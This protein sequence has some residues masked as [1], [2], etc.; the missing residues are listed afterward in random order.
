MT[1]LRK[2]SF[3]LLVAAALFGLMAAPVHAQVA[4]NCSGFP[5]TLTLGTHYT[6]SCFASGGVAP[7]GGAAAYNWTI[8]NGYPPGMSYGSFSNG[9]EFQVTG[10]P[11]VANTYTFTVTATDP[12]NN[13]GSASITAIVAASGGGTP[14]GTITLSYVSQTTIPA[15]QATTLTLVGTNFTASTVVYFNANILYPF[16]ISSSQMS[17][18]IPLGLAVAG[19]YSIYVHDPTTGTSTSQTITV[20]GSGGSGTLQITSL[21]P[22]SINVGYSQ[23]LPVYIYGSGFSSGQVVQF[24]TCEN[25]SPQYF[26]STELEINVPPSCFT[27][28]VTYNV[29]VGSS[30]AYQFVVGG[31]STGSG[32]ISLTSFAP[33]SLTAGLTQTLTLYGANFTPNTQVYFAGNYVSSTENSSGM[34]TATIPGALIT[35]GSLPVYVQ[36]VSTGQSAP[37][38]VPVTGSST[39]SGVTLSYISPNSIPAGSGSFTLSLFGS[40]FSNGN[41]VSFGSYNLSAVLVASGELQVAIPATYIATPGTLNV[42]VAGSNAQ[43]FTIT[44]SSTGSLTVTCS[45]ASGPATVN[46]AYSQTCSVSGGTSPYTWTVAGLPN[47]LSQSAYTGGSTVTISGTPTTQQ[48]YSYVV[49]V[50]DSSATRLIGSTTISGSVTSSTTSGYSITSLSPTSIPVGSGAT[51]LTVYGNGFTT[52]SQVYFNGTA[53]GTTYVSSTQL[54][55]S[56]A[57]SFL[58]TA[59]SDSVTVYT[60]GLYTNTLYL[61]VGSGSTS[62]GGLTVV[63]GPGVGPQTQYVLYSTICTASGGIQPYNWTTISLPSYLSLTSTT[64]SSVTLTGTPT[65]TGSYNFTVKV[66]DSSSPALSGSLQLAG[67]ILATSTTGGITLSSIS[68]TSTPVNS[69]T[70][71]LTLIG[72]GFTTSSQVTFSSIPITTTYVSGSELLATIPST[73]LTYSFAALI[74]VS[75]PGIGT[76]N[77]LSFIIGANVSNPVSITC[78]PGVGPTAPNIYYTQT[79]NANGGT[80]PFNWSIVSGALPAGLGL[81]S[82]T[83]VQTSITGYSTLNGPY[84]YTIQVVDSASPPNVGTAVFAG[85]TGTGTSTTNGLSLTSIAPGSIAPGAGN[86]TLTINGAGF[87]TSSVAYFNTTALA[88]TFVNS[89]QLTALIPSSLL[90]STTTA[91]ITVQSAGFTSNALSLS[92]GTGSSTAITISCS[93]T[94]GPPGSGA[95]YSTTCTATGGKAPYT[96]TIVN[97][98]L[99]TGIVL[100]NSNSA[101]ITISGVHISTA[102]SSEP[103][104]YTLQVTD[105]STPMQTADYPFAG[106]LPLGQGGVFAGTVTSMSPIS[107]PVNG[108]QFTLT[109][110]G[111]SFINGQSFILF[112]NTPL[113]T[114]Y[115]SSNELTGIVPASLL[116]TPGTVYVSVETSGIG[117]TNQVGFFVNGASGVAVAP[118]SLTFNYALG[119]VTPAAQTLSISSSTSVIVYSLSV[120][121]TANGI[122]WLSASPASG[123]IPGTVTVIAAPT[124]LAIGSYSGSITITGSGAGTGTTIPV[125]L[126]VLGTPGLK[127]SP[128]TMT[129]TAPAGTTSPTQTLQITSSDGQTPIPFTVTGVANNGGTW[130]SVTP[131]SGTTP[132]PVTVTTNAGS[133]PANT[134]YGQIN[135]TPTAG[136]GAALAI[137]VTFTVT[138][139]VTLTANPASLTFNGVTGQSNPAA[140]TVNLTASGSTAA[141][142][143]VAATTTSGGNWLTATASTGATPGT[144]SVTTNISG[145]AVGAYK[146]TVTVTSTGATNSPLAIPVTLNVANPSPLTTSPSSLTF[147]YQIGGST[148][149]AQTLNISAPSGSTGAF[150]YSIAAATNSGGNW[151]SVSSTSGTTPGSVSVSINTANLAVGSYSG[152]LTITASGAATTT[153]NV[154]LT[155]TPPPATLSVS[156]ATLTFNATAG[157]TSPS[158]QTVSV[159]TTNNVAA[160]Y[161]VTTSSAGNWLTATASGTTP[162]TISVSV[163]PASL[164]IGQYSGSLTIAS[165]GATNTPQTVNVTLNVAAPPAISVAPQSLS[166][167]VPGD[168]STPAPKTITVV[169]TGGNTNFT[170]SA[171]SQGGNWLSVTGG[172]TTPG[173]VVVSVNPAGLTPGQSYNGSVTINAPA[174][175]P[176]SLQVA[177]TL[178]LALQGAVPLQATPSALYLYYDQG[179]GSDLQHVLM[180]N[181]GGG[182]VLY[183]VVG[184]TQTCGNWLNVV[185]PLG[186]ATPST[187]GVV[188]ININPSGLNAQTCRGSI[189]IT[190]SNSNTATVPVYMAISSAAESI[191]LSQTA[192]N[193]VAGANGSA[194]AGQTFTILNPGDVSMPWNITTSTLSGGG[195]LSASP[196]AGNAPSLGQ[197]GTPI[198][199]TV[200]PQG[201]AAGV[202]YGTVQVAASGASNGPQSITVSLTVLGGNPPAQVTPDGVIL[203]GIN[204]N[205]NSQ[206]VNVTNSGSSAL[207]YSAIVTTDDGQNW[208]TV[209]PASGSISPGGTNAVNVSASLTG[210]G[211][212]LRHGTL[213]LAFSDG[214]VQTVDVQLALSGAASGSGVSA[215]GAANLAMEFLSPQQNFQAAAHVAIPI[216]V[217]VQDCLGNQLS[218]S[219]TGVD[220]LAGANN[221]DIRLNY[222]GNGIWA[223]TWT[224]ASASSA[225]SLTALAVEIVGGAEAAG[226]ITAN[227]TVTAAASNAPPLVSAVVNAGSFVLPGLVAPGTMVSIFG[228][229]LADGQ[230]QV[231]STPFPNSL[232][233]AQFSVKGVAMPLF[234]ASSGQVNAILPIGLTADER[235]QL[236]VVRDTTQSAPVDLLVADSDPGIFAVNSQGTGQGA[237]LVGGTSQ[238]A[239]P[240]GSIPGA[241]AAPASA[242]QTISMFVSGLGTVSNPPADGSPS[243]GNSLTTATPTVTIGGVPAQVTYSGLAPGEVGLYQV[244]AVV[245]AGVPTGSAVPVVITLGNGVSNT[246]TMAIQ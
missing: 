210:L 11:S 207:S 155:V 202:Y 168:G 234:Y 83:G 147:S 139:P 165:P 67:Q 183:Q 90:I 49:Q 143:T 95:N 26:G 110:L 195:W 19:S 153:V 101:T 24:G 114:T 119:G 138:A 245:P 127:A 55:A 78:S 84:S 154:A 150:N 221:A 36:D 22:S 151:L 40:N 194:P 105:S 178:T 170:A 209:S 223:G 92:I 189:S 5:S 230:V 62:S 97:G 142:Y 219:N 162:G 140:Q 128:L 156:P 123:T 60:S 7:T 197:P 117:N 112:G 107:A 59:G 152:T 188:G 68:P 28:A 236:I 38:Y 82:T 177:V 214:T 14:S 169:S 122:T 69:G 126:N 116:V 115:I 72:S 64:G 173:S 2:V 125:T 205:A 226:S 20:T 29:T 56:I 98:F 157:G 186:I 61:T 238:I 199:V 161:T 66:T 200:N 222:T 104:N 47:G 241:N 86:T 33:P 164:S 46:V 166:F 206:A 121:A 91:S 239:A 45:P 58:A 41:I 191:L 179:A 184:Q 111:N 240:S 201:L 93:P 87:G 225:S 233:G 52:S 103:Y 9:E 32:S 174:S 8:T 217:L 171:F 196:N 136:Y 133:L 65:S 212:G 71:T 96:W 134:Y 3:V 224:P 54:T 42:S 23:T 181:S 34:I 113:A 80:G 109:V 63:C 30:N 130:L 237:I 102:T 100:G 21:V 159:S 76:S 135:V 204:G 27:T 16:N 227:G 198:T 193:F 131:S 79:C 12:A 228:S 220:V 51:A 160:N 108:S 88:T 50:T 35:S 18:T 146:G 43:T 48:S 13:S 213:R 17:V 25:I 129:F 215:C 99:P 243:S 232:E 158:P 216:K 70:V 190:D 31:T 57:A 1:S 118:S 192:M 10:T 218:S 144:I 74:T 75:T 167:F 211:T 242:G 137:P 149:S 77:S 53:V 106:T 4:V 229:S 124:G 235:D 208:L 231:F 37:L 163:N 39:G 187:P 176:S 182:S 85:T 44:G 132:A 246:V 185:T 6:L 244:N 141:N 175:N 148:P 172:G 180:I 81:S 203:T 120:S 94:T 15:G 89:T 73:L 145:L